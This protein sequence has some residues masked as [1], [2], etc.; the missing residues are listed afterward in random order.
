MPVPVS[1]PPR[2]RSASAPADRGAL[3]SPAAAQHAQQQA[4]L[5]R[6]QAAAARADGAA[7]V[8]AA[9]EALAVAERR[10]RVLGWIAEEAEPFAVEFETRVRMINIVRGFRE[11][12]P[13]AQ[14]DL[15]ALEAELAA[16]TERDAELETRLGELDAERG[17]LAARLAEARS[18]GQVGAVGTLRSELS[19]VDEVTGDLRGQ[20]A[21]ARGRMDQIGVPG[22][23]RL[24]DQ[25]RRE[26]ESLRRQH[27]QGVAALGPDAENEV[28]QPLVSRLL[29]HGKAC[30]GEAEQARLAAIVAVLDGEPGWTAIMRSARE[31]NDARDRYHRGETA[32]QAA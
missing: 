17:S 25:A 26:V 29:D 6:A 11:R 3:D 7:L 2:G 31:Y 21:A 23:D 18:A 1:A 32:E 27:A 24:L 9:R 20:L 28:V 14:A 10:A 4:A 13:A 12:L 22:A 5:I 16:L 19:A 15:D 8:Q 30:E